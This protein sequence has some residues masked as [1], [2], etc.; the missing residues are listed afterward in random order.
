MV[1][2]YVDRAEGA[3]RFD[4]ATGSG[5]FEGVVLRPE[6]TIAAGAEETARELHGR[7]HKLCFIANSVNFPV[8]CEPRI[9]RA[10]A[11]AQELVSSG[12]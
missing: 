9:V 10:G 7:A 12:R 1:T 4:A 8:V 3:M 6:V 5:H 2:G 11:P